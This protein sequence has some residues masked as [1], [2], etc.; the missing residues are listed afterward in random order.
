[1]VGVSV[2]A[3]TLDR[4]FELRLVV[5]QKGAMLAI[6]PEAHELKVA[7]LKRLVAG[8]SLVQR[9]AYEQP[10]ER[11]LCVAC[12][13]HIPSANHI[14]RADARSALALWLTATRQA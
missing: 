3:I 14:A 7:L 12:T 9:S 4:A 8:A 2:R 10:F 13:V 5:D 11:Q 1:M 6:H